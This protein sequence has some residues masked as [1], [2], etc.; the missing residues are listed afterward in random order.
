MLEVLLGLVQLQEYVG[1]PVPPV[2]VAVKLCAARL[3]ELAKPPIATLRTVPT[4]LDCVLE[5]VKGVPDVLSVTVHVTA[6]KPT[7]AGVKVGFCAVAE[8]NSLVL[9]EPSGR[10]QAHA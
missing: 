2:G 1:E 6:Y 9:A 5:A 4:V 7:L 10:V 8:E 3:A